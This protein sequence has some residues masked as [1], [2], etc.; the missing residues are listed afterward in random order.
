MLIEGQFD[1]NNLLSIRCLYCEITVREVQKVYDAR[2]ELETTYWS[3]VRQMLRKVGFMDPGKQMFFRYFNWFT[4]LSEENVRLW[5]RWTYATGVQSYW[6]NYK[7]Y[8]NK[9]SFQWSFQERLVSLKMRN[10]ANVIPLL[11]LKE[12]VIMVRFIFS[13]LLEWLNTVDGPKGVA[14]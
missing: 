4:T 11:G 14:L 12:N 9:R 13:W 2:V 7:A 3:N 5:C 8:W 10:R 6:L 1:P